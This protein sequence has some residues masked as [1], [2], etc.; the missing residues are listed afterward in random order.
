MNPAPAFAN[1][2]ESPV[3]PDHAAVDADAIGCGAV[4]HEAERLAGELRI[5]VALDLRAHLDT[6]RRCASP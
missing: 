1:T 6:T 2:T 3:E 4:H 5:A